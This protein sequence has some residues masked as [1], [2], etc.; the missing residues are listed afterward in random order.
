MK[1]RLTDCGIKSE[2]V[3]RHWNVL[4]CSRKYKSRRSLYSLIW[5]TDL[6]RKLC[7]R[8]MI[9]DAVPPSTNFWNGWSC[10]PVRTGR[11]RCTMPTPSSTADWRT[12][13]WRFLPSVQRLW[14]PSIHLWGH[15]DLHWIS[16]WNVGPSGQRSRNLSLWADVRRWNRPPQSSPKRF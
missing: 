2:R 16:L 12:P 13:V 4:N 7:S 15:A 10:V 1:I 5:R 3:F 11:P 14:W 6:S 9:L 8:T